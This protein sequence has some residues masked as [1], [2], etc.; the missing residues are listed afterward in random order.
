MRPV[1]PEEVLRVRDR[2]VVVGRRAEHEHDGGVHEPQRE[3]G[4]VAL[5]GGE[6]A[7]SGSRLKR[8]VRATLKRRSPGGSG[9]SAARSMRTSA[10]MWANGLDE[11]GR[12]LVAAPTGAKRT[13][14]PASQ[15]EGV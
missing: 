8:S 1:A 4:A 10:A 5:V 15:L 12:Y 11:S 14:W 9:L 6:Q 13:G 7:G 3:D 2:D